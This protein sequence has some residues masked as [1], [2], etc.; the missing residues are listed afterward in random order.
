MSLKRHPTFVGYVVQVVLQ[1]GDNDMEYN[2]KHPITQVI[3]ALDTISTA[4]GGAQNLKYYLEKALQHEK[5][6]F[7]YAKFKVDDRV[8]LRKTMKFD[9]DHGWKHC[10]HF[11]KRGVRATIAA[12][13]YD[14][15]FT[16][17]IIFD[18]ET[19]M[20]HEGNVEDVGSRHTFHFSE[21]SLKVL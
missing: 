18:K 4:C 11:M 9:N 10:E 21:T 17:D 6:L 2:E 5:D 7:K 12:I 16:Y 20:D 1:L 15:E 8:K 13:D 19:W 14:T 3:E